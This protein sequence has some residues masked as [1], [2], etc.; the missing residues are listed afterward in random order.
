MK[1]DPKNLDQLLK[2]AG[3]T[4]LGWQNGWKS[5]ML[6]QEGNVT[7]DYNLYRKFG[8]YSKD[9]YPEYNNCR[10]LGHK[11]DEVQHTR[12]GSE[13]TQSCDICK[14]YFKYDCSG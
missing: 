2:E 7:E 3:Y 1:G 6:D 11:L 12:S 10:D 9:K 4:F 8:G 14:I 5:I 13:N